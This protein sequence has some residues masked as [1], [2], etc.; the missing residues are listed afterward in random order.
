MSAPI[1]EDYRFALLAA[2]VATLALAPLNVVVDF[3]YELMIATILAVCIFW[4]LVVTVVFRRPRNPT[5]VDLVIIGWG[6]WPF[7]AAFDF[8]ACSLM[9]WAL[10]R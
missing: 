5:R 7:V 6:C 9:Y 4:A 2:M 10:S 8:A 1:A 3:G